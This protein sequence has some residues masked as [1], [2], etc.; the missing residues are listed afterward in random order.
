MK[1]YTT[2]ISL[3][4]KTDKQLEELKRELEIPKSAIIRFSVS[5]LYKK[6]KGVR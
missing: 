6:I 1:N 2:T 5:Q 3:T 4:E